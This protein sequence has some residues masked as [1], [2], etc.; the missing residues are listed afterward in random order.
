MPAAP[1][2]K[3][4]QQ[5]GA[6]E[7]PFTLP[8][9]AA[10]Q[11]HA[12]TGFILFSPTPVGQPFMNWTEPNPWERLGP[13]STFNNGAVRFASP[14]PAA[15]ETD[16]GRMTFHPGT[17]VE[18]RGQGGPILHSGELRVATKKE[19]R[20]EFQLDRNLSLRI[21]TP[22]DSV[23]LISRSHSPV[24]S[25]SFIGPGP[26]AM[27]T[28]IAMIKGTAVSEFG[29]T[30]HNLNQHQV[31]TAEPSENGTGLHFRTVNQQSLKDWPETTN[32]ETLTAEMLG[33]YFKG[34]RSLP[35]AL[36]E[37]ESDMMKPVRD[38]ALKIA[39]WLDRDDLVMS[40]LTDQA[41]QNLNTSA[42]E[43]LRTSARSGS[44]AAARIFA[45]LARE[46][47]MQPVDQ[48][49]LARLLGDPE[50]KADQAWKKQLVALLEHNSSLIRQLTLQQLMSIAGRD[51]MGYDPLA[52]SAKGIQAWQTWL[53]VKP[54]TKP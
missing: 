51:D 42:I 21:Q 36:V 6:A 32:S 45:K 29:G 19:A 15:F 35:V 41:S 3:A 34:N 20:I 30:M 9:S 31:L 5:P 7:Q 48:A 12:K 27:Q 46:L 11:D 49:F 16:Q 24:S 8:A 2:A 39:I 18:Y 43:A 33:R 52:P 28:S 37:A 17:L 13:Q 40:A 10:V 1:P 14:E 23:V 53:G 4:E 47:E 44:P 50:L 54:E 22:A 26:I 25:K 38:Q